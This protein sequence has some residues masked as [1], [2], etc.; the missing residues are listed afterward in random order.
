MRRVL[1]RVAAGVGWR[2]NRAIHL[3]QTS[4][5]VR[6]A[7]RRAG[8]ALTRARMRR[9]D[10]RRIPEAKDEIRL[11][12]ILRNEA[13]RLPYFLQYYTDLGV[14]RFF[15]M[16]NMSTD[17]SV[18][19]LLGHPRAHV[20]QTAEPL[21]RQAY[22]RDVLLRRYGV[23]HWCVVLDTDEFL[24]YPHMDRVS[25]RELCALLEREGASAMQCA[26]LD[27]YPKEPLCEARYRQ[28]EDPRLTAGYFEA[29][30]MREV[31]WPNAFPARSDGPLHV[32][33]G[34]VRLRV[35]DDDA[36]LSKIS[37]IRFQESHLLTGGI[38]FVEQASIARARGA[39]LHFK[40]LPSIVERARD[41]AQREAAS[42]DAIGHK[43]I[44][45]KL[46]ENPRLTLYSDESVALRSSAQ[47]LD[48]GLMRSCPSLDRLASGASN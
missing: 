13:L 23:G 18:S 11:I 17:E 20:F 33:W 1:S 16:D 10:S 37:L 30:T 28:G 4:P 45:A 26:L 34:G 39:T 31:P 19:I 21:A 48:L 41:E 12:M 22:W 3:L 44:V 5:R 14:D 2:I 46:D 36:C 24:Y 32:Y 7:R 35:F 6:L 40:F 43:R 38:H 27:M 8:C 15:V 25:L 42:G 9:L 47:L 29:A